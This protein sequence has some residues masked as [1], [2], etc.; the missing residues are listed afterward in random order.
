M[1]VT[2]KQYY[3]WDRWQRDPL[4]ALRL[5][6]RIRVQR[7]LVAYW[8]AYRRLRNATS[9]GTAEW[10]LWVALC[11]AAMANVLLWLNVQYP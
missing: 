3:L 5:R 7:T 9:L 11:R 10:R 4:H 1:L 2:E 6:C 8:G